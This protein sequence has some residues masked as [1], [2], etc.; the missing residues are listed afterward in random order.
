MSVEKKGA[1]VL[2]ITATTKNGCAC[3]DVLM[4]TLL[5]KTPL[6]DWAQRHFNHENHES[7]RSVVNPIHLTVGGATMEGAIMEEKAVEL[8][9]IPVIGAT[10]RDARLC[11][12]ENPQVMNAPMAH[13]LNGPTAYE[14]SMMGT[15][16]REA[17]MAQSIQC[18]QQAPDTLNF[19]MACMGDT[20]DHH[21][22]VVQADPPAANTA[23]S[24]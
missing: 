24:F 16:T 15:I 10:T 1:R 2:E 22:P 11:F 18:I 7:Q 21:V 12:H 13:A 5:L 8:A 19:R 23:R 20:T 6:S 14:V 4:K 17:D 9:L 3:V